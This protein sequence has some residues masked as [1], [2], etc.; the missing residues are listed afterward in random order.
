MNRKLKY[1]AILIILVSFQGMAQ[2][3]GYDWIKSFGNID[4]AFSMIDLDN[5]IIIAGSFT[6]TLTFSDQTVTSAGNNTSIF[7]AKFDNQGNL[8]WIVSDPLQKVDDIAVDHNGNIYLTATI[9]HYSLTGSIFKTVSYIYVAKFDKSGNKMWISTSAEQTLDKPG[10]NQATSI[11]CDSE[12]SAYITGYYINSL[13][14]GSQH[15]ENGS[16]YVAKFDSTGFPVWLKNISGINTQIGNY[17]GVGNDILVDRNG[18]LFITGYFRVS[19]ANYIFL[20]RLNTNG[21][22]Q[23]LTQIIGSDRT[24]GERLQSDNDGNLYLAAIFN[25]I[26]TVNGKDYNAAEGGNNPVIFK[27]LNDSIVTVTHIEVYVA[28]S[29]I[30]RD[31]CIDDNQNLFYIA[32]IRKDFIYYPT[33]MRF[34]SLGNL[35]QQQEIAQ[36]YTKYFA[37]LTSI[38]H[39]TSGNLF[40]TGL[41]MQMAYFGDSLVGFPNDHSSAFIGKINFDEVY[42]GIPYLEKEND[43]IIIYP[44]VTRESICIESYSENLSNKEMKIYNSA[45][46]MVQQATLSSNKTWINISGISQGVYF[47]EISSN[48][49]R[50]THKIVK[51]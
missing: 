36:S 48:G 5:N 1:S 14:F 11:T 51:L 44:S 3:I 28:Q 13:S 37:V 46:K 29:I 6:G 43:V 41:L 19:K 31:F 21:D 20:I 25:G 50:E 32:S 23:N 33:I 47:V 16:I 17:Q 42:N 49:F 40:L 15:L 30:D 38:N 22:P 34:D 18:Q 24:S 10:G 26:V 7:I 2:R 39:D 12:G 35:V 45:G 9:K 8:A 4:A 27:F